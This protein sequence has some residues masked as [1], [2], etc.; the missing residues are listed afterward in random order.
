MRLPEERLVTRYFDTADRRLWQQGMTLRHRTTG[1]EDEGVWTLKLPH[2]SAG[3]A[4]ERTEVTWPGASH[5]FPSDATDI[6]RGL[7]RREP[8]EQLTVLE[9][10]RQRLVLRDDKDNELAEIDDDV[11]FV[12]G[13]P[14]QGTRFRQ[15]EMEFRDE[16]WRGHQVVH[17]LEKA[18]ARLEKETKLAKAIALP[19]P[20]ASSLVDGHSTMSDVVRASLT[21]GLDRL[22]AHDWQLRLTVPDPAAEDV[23]QARVATRRVRSDLKTFGDILDPL[24][25]SHLRSELKWLGAVLGELRDLDVLSD[26]LSDMPVPVRQRL[27]VAANR[28]GKAAGRGIGERALREFGGPTARRIGILAC[29]RWCCV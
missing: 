12:A 13:G 3:M 6:L 23:H 19:P 22:L 10:T 8:L 16:T 1:E 4:L 7:L 28:G 17:Q 9:T 25:R 26:G 14:R 20:A 18:G 21:A 24:W 11:V 29:R 2:A 5:E 15:V 27:A